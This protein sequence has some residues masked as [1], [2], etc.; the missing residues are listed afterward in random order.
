MKEPPKQSEPRKRTITLTD[1]APIRIVEAEWP[2]IAQGSCSFNWTPEDGWGIEIRVRRHVDFDNRAD[3]Q[4]GAIIH[5][6]YSYRNSRDEDDQLVRV[7]RLLTVKQTQDGLWG[8]IREVGDE[9][10][11]RIRLDDLKGH[12]VYAI[13]GVFAQL[14]PHDVT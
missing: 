11:Q 3:S 2:V 4:A 14:A 9:L 1:R 6:K 12:V 7:G 10:R 8:H 5:A 13:D